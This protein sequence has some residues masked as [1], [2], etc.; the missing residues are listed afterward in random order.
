MPA[1]LGAWGLN[2]DDLDPLGH[3]SSWVHEP[4]SEAAK[5]E[6]EEMPRK[7]Q[8]DGGMCWNNH[9]EKT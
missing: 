7:L 4:L 5:E 9:H 8:T 6:V 3:A 1:M 2:L